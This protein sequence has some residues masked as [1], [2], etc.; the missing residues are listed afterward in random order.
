MARE[1]PL[2][3]KGAEVFCHLL[4]GADLFAVSWTQ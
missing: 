1:T 4:T 3:V 2:A